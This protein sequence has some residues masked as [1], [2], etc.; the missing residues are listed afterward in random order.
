M[1]STIPNAKDILEIGRQVTLLVS[2]IGT[3]D[4]HLTSK[5]INFLG[6]RKYNEFNKMD[7]ENTY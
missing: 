2:L 6:S 4:S 3:G 1:P 7:N 5:L